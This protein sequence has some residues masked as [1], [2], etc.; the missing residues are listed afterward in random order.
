MYKY[1]CKV[2]RVVDGDT[3]VVQVDLGFSVKVDIKFR[4]SSINTPELR[5]DQ[6][7]KGLAAKAEVERL[8]SLGQV[9]VQSEKPVKAD[10]YGRWLGTFFVQQGDVSTN[11]NETLIASGFAELYKG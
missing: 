4:L 10:K 9:T 3:V 11:V 1:A 7:E 2:L 8:L 5:G 6:K